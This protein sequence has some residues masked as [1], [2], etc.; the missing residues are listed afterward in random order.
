[1]DNYNRENSEIYLNS[2]K[3]FLQSGN[4]A[5]AGKYAQKAATANPDNA[6]AYILEI[7][8]LL[9]YRSMEDALVCRGGGVLCSFDGQVALGQTDP[10]VAQATASTYAVLMNCTDT[11]VKEMFAQKNAQ[12][13]EMLHRHTAYGE[14]ARAWLEKHDLKI[15]T[16]EDLADFKKTMEPFYDLPDCQTLM[17]NID[18]TIRDMQ[19]RK[20]RADAYQSALDTTKKR[21]RRRR[22]CKVLVALAL[23]LGIGFAALYFTV[24]RPA[25]ATRASL[26]LIAETPIGEVVQYGAYPQGNGS[27]VSPIEWLPIAKQGDRVLLISK[28]CIDGLPYNREK[29]DTTWSACSLR[30]W[31]NT[32]FYAAAFSDNEKKYILQAQNANADHPAGTPGGDPTEDRV[33]LLSAEEA[34]RYLTSPALRQS[35]PTLYA[36]SNFTNTTNGYSFYW[37][38]SIGGAQTCALGVKADGTIAGYGVNVDDST[39]GV[40]PAIWISLPES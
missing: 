33:F 36:R 4:F 26:T 1:M 32:D 20:Q 11:K 9:R 18:N 7:L 14:A 15:A 35:E 22:I 8:A 16:G 19:A 27:A 38:R 25:E 30:A 13:T 21:I 2:A 5:D 10:A 31:L 3:N 29:L 6:G 28:S 37:L 12:R 34:E 40:R 39:M 17:Q 24:L 23:V